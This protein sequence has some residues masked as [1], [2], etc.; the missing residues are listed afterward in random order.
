MQRHQVLRSASL[1]GLGV[2]PVECSIYNAYIHLITNAKRS[3]YIENQFFMSS[4]N[5]VANALVHRINQAHHEKEKFRALVVLPL[6][7]GFEGEVD[8]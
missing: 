2:Q 8:N 1:W 3:V 4:E 7:P 6:L 5:E